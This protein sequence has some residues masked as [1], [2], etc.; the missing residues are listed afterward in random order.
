MQTL[1]NLILAGISVTI[2]ESSM[3]TYE[4]LSGLYYAS[5]HDIGKPVSI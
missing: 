2:Q 3:V 1:K 4:D 5:P